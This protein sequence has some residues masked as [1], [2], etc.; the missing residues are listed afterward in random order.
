MCEKENDEN[1]KAVLEMLRHNLL[2][3]L[4][5]QVGKEGRVTCNYSNVAR[6]ALSHH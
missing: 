2:C 1:L 4:I 5:S 6:V 3:E